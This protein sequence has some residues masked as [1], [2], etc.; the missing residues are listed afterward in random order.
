MISKLSDT[1]WRKYYAGAGRVPKGKMSLA[2]EKNTEQST[3]N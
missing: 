3:M 2:P 1:Y